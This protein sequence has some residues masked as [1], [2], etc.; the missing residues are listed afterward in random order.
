[1]QSNIETLLRAYLHNEVIEGVVRST[2]HLAIES[3]LPDV[4]N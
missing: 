1:M 2:E 3:R 4:F